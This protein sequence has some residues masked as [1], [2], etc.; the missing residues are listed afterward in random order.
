MLT[1]KIANYCLQGA[2]WMPQ[3]DVDM[4]TGKQDVGRVVFLDD[5]C[6]LQNNQLI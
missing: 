6:I 5:Y 3:M 2:G 4:E 1:F